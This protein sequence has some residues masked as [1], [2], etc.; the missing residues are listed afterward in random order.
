MQVRTLL[1]AGLLLC[2]G[3]Q[4]LAAP[5]T[6]AA[7]VNGSDHLAQVGRMGPVRLSYDVR[8]LGASGVRVLA[9]RWPFKGPED[10]PALEWRF[11]QPAGT[12]LVR[13]HSLPIGVYRVVAIALD[14]QGN[15]VARQSY[16]VY[17]EYGGPRA[18]EG[19]NR[20]LDL[21]AEPPPL[22]GVGASYVASE[23]LPRIELSPATS[24]LK[25]GQEVLLRA[26]ARNLDQESPLRWHLEG[27][28]RLEV[29]EDG[30]AKYTAPGGSKNQ[31]ARVRC[32]A[33]G[34]AAQP[35]GATVLTTS[36][37]IDP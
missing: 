10:P 18:W 14:A 4:A 27:P 30:Q 7:L 29:L 24:V 28:G 2:L 35:G 11:E 37:Q 19:M 13:F 34:T 9:H 22:A 12:P 33:P 21:R 6:P 36:V 16:P 32:E 26:R 3:L 25:P 31:I 8:G 5:R 17:V 1:I 15:E 23:D 20:D